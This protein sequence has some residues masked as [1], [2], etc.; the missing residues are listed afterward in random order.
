MIDEERWPA[1]TLFVVTHK[2]ALLR[3]TLRRLNDHSSCQEVVDETFLIAWR[4]WDDRPEP[5][6]ELSWLYGIS[7]HVLSNSRRSRDRRERLYVR[8]SMERDWDRDGLESSEVDI[9][10]LTHAFGLLKPDDQELLRLV[11]WEELTYREIALELEISENA[12]GI[13]IN[14]AKKNLRTLLQ[15]TDDAPSGVVILREGFEL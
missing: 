9:E 15:P 1:F 11:Y 13:R 4:R 2:T 8:L 3:Y 10:A 12:V 7:Y 5:H 6:R 14:R